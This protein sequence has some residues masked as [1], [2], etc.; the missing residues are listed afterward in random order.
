[1]KKCGAHQFWAFGLMWKVERQ[2]INSCFLRCIV[3]IVV[4][5]SSRKSIPHWLKLFDQLRQYR[6][7]IDR[8]FLL[9]WCTASVAAQ[10]T[11]QQYL[12][13]GLQQE[14]ARPVGV[15]LFLWLILQNRHC[16]ITTAS[17]SLLKRVSAILTAGL[18][19]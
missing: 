12:H 19:A 5:H 15:G 14:I 3:A 6:V 8:C 18:F 13:T 1:M 17:R 2:I 11:F 16:S 9:Y 4:V 10:I 7:I